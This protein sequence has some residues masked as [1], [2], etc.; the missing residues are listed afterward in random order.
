MKRY[1]FIDLAKGIGILL[2]ILGHITLTPNFLR[3]WLYTFHIPLFFFLSGYVF[4]GNSDFKSFILK[5]IKSLLIP[6]LFFGLVLVLIQIWQSE[7]LNILNILVGFLNLITQKK[8]LTVWFLSCIFIVNIIMWCII[9]FTK[10]D[11]Y[12]SL[13][14]SLVIYLIGAFYNFKIGSNL[15]W[16][17]NSAFMM[18]IFFWSGYSLKCINIENLIMKIKKFFL[19]IPVLFFING[20]LGVINYIIMSHEIVDVYYN[21]YGNYIIYLFA[22]LSGTLGIFL[23]AYYTRSKFYIIRYIGQ[24]SLTYYALHQGIALP[25]V[26]SIVNQLNFNIRNIFIKL[27]LAIIICCGVLIIIYPINF[28]LNKTPFKKAIGK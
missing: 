5:K 25:I 12:K 10:G 3:I 11:L 18:T 22:A 26:M 21:R 13:L 17:I 2:V 14:M 20:V 23:L 7:P 6:Y 8:Y 24:N 16:N 27:C 19:V 9:R 4:S 15:P 1:E 28:I